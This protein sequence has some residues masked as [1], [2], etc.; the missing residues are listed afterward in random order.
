MHELSWRLLTV[1]IA[2]VLAAGACSSGPGES[3]TPTSTSVPG[4]SS[5]PAESTTTTHPATSPPSTS[6]AGGLDLSGVQWVTHGPEGIRLDDDTLVLVTEPFPAGV[7]RD[8]R[9]G[10]A[11][12]DSK[13]LWWLPSGEIE[14]RLVWEGDVE[15]I[16][17]VED[18]SGP[19]AIVW[20]EGPVYLRLGDGEG[21]AEPVGTGVKVSPDRPWDREWTAANGLS[22]RIVEPE[23][24]EDAEGQPSVVLEPAR[25]TVTRGDEV[26][27]DVPVGGP[28]EPWVRLHDFDGQIVLLSQGP[29]EPA[30]P[31][32]TFLLIDLA[33]GEV[34][35][36]FVAAGTGATLTGNDVGW[37]GPV[38]TPELPG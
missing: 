35:N 30:M 22:V 7:A 4:A 25:L 13:G 8:R 37:S 38:I 27:V 31:E 20:K 9:G 6:N 3:A 2:T 29:F 24:E 1:L 33:T 16:A 5:P 11:F 23:V 28:D 12:T 18:T 10:I 17:V 26:L 34:V 32:E 36:S 15:L 14:P 19:V 21:V